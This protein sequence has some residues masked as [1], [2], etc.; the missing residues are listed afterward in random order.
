MMLIDPSALATTTIRSSPE[1]QMLEDTACFRLCAL[2]ST[3]VELWYCSL[4]FLHSCLR[5]RSLIVADTASI[6]EIS[7]N[8]L[9]VKLAQAA[10]REP[11]SLE[12]RNHRLESFVSFG[13]QHIEETF[14]VLCI[15]AVTSNLPFSNEY[16]LSCP[17]VKATA[18]AAS[19]PS[20]RPFCQAK[21]EMLPIRPSSNTELISLV[22]FLH[23]ESPDFLSV[24][25]SWLKRCPSI[26]RL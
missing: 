18:I 20:P 21:A 3:K 22:C 7:S 12:K 23:V 16:T 1:S 24:L 11:S 17:L 14:A 13:F 26:P 19:P 9:F 10:K 6:L 15:P 2:S 5:G 25:H 8:S 4:V